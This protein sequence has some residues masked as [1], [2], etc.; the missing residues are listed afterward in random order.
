MR[1]NTNAM[2]ETIRTLQEEN[3]ALKSENAALKYEISRLRGH[4]DIFVGASTYLNAD[5][6]EEVQS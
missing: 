4:K 5:D 1:T 2:V 6:G 3:A